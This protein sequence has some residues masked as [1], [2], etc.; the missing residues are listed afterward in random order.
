M[1]VLPTC[2]LHPSTEIHSRLHVRLMLAAPLTS[3]HP[4]CF[5]M[6]TTVWLQAAWNCHQNLSVFLFIFRFWTKLA[7]MKAN[8]VS[9]LIKE[10]S[11]L[12]FTPLKWIQTKWPHVDLLNMFFVYCGMIIVH[13][14]IACDTWGWKTIWLWG[15]NEVLTNSWLCFPNLP[16]IQALA[17]INDFHQKH[18]CFCFS[19]WLF[20]KQMVNRV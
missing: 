15:L 19:N 5:H 7:Q 17:R 12:L 11:L 16:E 10:V 13:W 4:G 20:K 14:K 9:V 6:F 1:S 2:R 18:H 3:R 8:I